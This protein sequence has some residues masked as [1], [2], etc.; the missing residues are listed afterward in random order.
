MAF[1]LFAAWMYIVLKILQDIFKA[2]NLSVSD[3]SSIEAGH[4]QLSQ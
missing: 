4:M 1:L 2:T 3:P